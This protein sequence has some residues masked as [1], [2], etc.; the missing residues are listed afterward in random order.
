MTVFDLV[1]LCSMVTTHPL[2]R[3]ILI[4]SLDAATTFEELCEEVREMCRLHQGQP[5]TLKWVD[6]EGSPGPV[7]SVE[8]PESFVPCTWLNPFLGEMWTMQL[9]GLQPL[10]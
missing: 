2:P 8:I 1:S 5:L 7:S 3:D 9:K 4:T 10:P 6:N